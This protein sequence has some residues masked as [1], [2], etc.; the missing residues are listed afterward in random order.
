RENH[1]ISLMLTGKYPSR[2]CLPHFLLRETCESIRRAT[3]CVKV[4]TDNLYNYLKA[5]PSQSIDK[6]ALSDVTSCITRKQFADLLTEGARTS[7]PGGRLCY[8]NFVAK[9]SVSGN[10]MMQRDDA[11]CASLDHDDLAFV[12]SFEVATIAAQRLSA[13]TSASLAASIV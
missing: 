2:T 10:G 9:Y 8:R 6:F 5:L 13:D 4:V 3:S 11:L 7:K 12:Y 1:W